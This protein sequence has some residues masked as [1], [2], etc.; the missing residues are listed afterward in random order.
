MKADQILERLNDAAKS[1][2]FLEQAS[3]IIDEVSLLPNSFDA[4]EPILRFMEMNPEMDF[5]TPGTLVHF[6]ERFYGQGYEQML[7]DSIRRKPALHTVWMLN[8]IINGT[9]DTVEKS[10]LIQMLK[11]VT[12]SPLASSAIQGLAMHFLSK[13]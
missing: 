11:N 9:D 12:E 5:G 7:I 13:K 8:R 4:V 10:R 2:D 3:E 6:V 1:N